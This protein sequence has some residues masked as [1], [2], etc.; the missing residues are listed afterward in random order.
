MFV[1]QYSPSFVVSRSFF[2]Q[3]C[4]F[5]GQKDKDRKFRGFAKK[6]TIFDLGSCYVFLSKAKEEKNQA[7][8]LRRKV[9]ETVMCIST[10]LFHSPVN[11]S[12][13]TLLARRKI[14]IT[15]SLRPPR[16]STILK[17]TKR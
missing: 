6:D 4:S 15:F 11:L 7:K 5:L 16:N 8:K 12:S 9:K 14:K 2:L 13:L 3:V 1:K 17:P 10:N